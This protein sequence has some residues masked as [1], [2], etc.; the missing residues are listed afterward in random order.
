MKSAGRWW[1]SFHS[2]HPTTWPKGEIVS[3]PLYRAEPPASLSAEESAE[4]SARLAALTQS[5]L[6]LEG[7]LAALADEVARPRLAGVLRNLAARL[8]RGE[9]L[10]S[11]I[12]AQGP[13][14]P[15]YL[16]GL[17]VAGVRS[18]RLPI[19]LDQFAVLARRQ[20]D[21]RRR[22]LMTLAYPVVL[23]GV[24]AGLMVGCHLFFAET[25][26]EV[27]R[28]FH[29]TLPVVTVLYFRFRARSPGRSWD[30][31]LRPRWCRWLPFFCRWAPGS[32]AQRGGFRSWE[33]SSAMTALPSLRV[34]WPCCWKRESR[35]RR[36]CV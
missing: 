17:I 34:S 26:S 30:W 6:P 36:P 31:Q 33:Q 28:D 10:E 29:T 7:G 1:D 8:E 27:V 3:F 25:F 5:G 32:A 16:R 24:M 35:C 22:I 20:R 9:K 21:L 2:A 19:V 12:A 23:L 14:L 11:A 15:A 4:L 18:G 13:R